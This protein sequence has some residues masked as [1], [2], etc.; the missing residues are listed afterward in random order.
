M[1]AVFPKVTVCNSAFAVTEYA[2][3]IIKDLNQ[4]FFPDIDIFNQSQMTNISYYEM[5]SLGTLFY[6]YLYSINLKSFSDAS[7]KNLSHSLEDVLFECQ[8]NNEP[9]SA[10]DFSWRWDP[11]YGNCYSFNS[12]FNASGSPISYK[13]SLLPGAIFGLQLN[14]YVGYYDKLNVFNTGFFTP[15]GMNAPFYGLNVL[16]ENNTYLSDDKANVIALNGGTVNYMSM[17]R[18]FTSKLPKPYSDCEI[19]NIDPGHI[20]SPYFNL[21]LN[22]PYQYN[23]ELCV[24][25]C[26]QHQVIESCNCSKPFYLD[27]YNLSCLRDK[28]IYCAYSFTMNISIIQGCILQCPIE[29][30]STQFTFALTSQTY[31]GD[32]FAALVKSSS[33]LIADFANTPITA[34]TASNKFVQLNLFYDSLTYSLSTDSPSMDIVTLL[35]NVGGTLGLFLGVSVLS[36]C[37]LVHVMVES[38][39]LVKHRFKQ[40]QNVLNF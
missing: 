16:I 30:N 33:T 14:V 34:E 1:P 10:S 40:K 38:F 9:C 29:C 27:L 21:I 31:M 37:E 6:A 39:V 19:D 22:S 18:R 5:Q 11:I 25:Q 24:I 12:G 3:E 17:Q 26:I 8:F 35:S 15:Y 7:R 36:L 4:K 20:D 2:Y 32:L 23:Q 28:E 13:Q